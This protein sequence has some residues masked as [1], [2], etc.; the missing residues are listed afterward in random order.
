MR[1]GLGSSPDHD[2]A[3][4]GEVGVRQHGQ[5]DVAVPAGPERTSYWSRPTSPLAASKQASIVQRVPATRTRSAS[6]VP[7]AAWVR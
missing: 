5:R 3:Q 1:S 4:H 7:S 2:R 6:A